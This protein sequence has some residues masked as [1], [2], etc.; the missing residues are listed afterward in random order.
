MNQSHV[1]AGLAALV[2]LGVLGLVLLLGRTVEPLASGPTREGPRTRTSRPAGKPVAMATD[3]VSLEIIL[4]LKD[5][6]PTVWD[7]QVMVS[8]GKV[9]S[10][11]LQRVGPQQGKVKDATFTVRTFRRAL[12]MQQGIV[13]PIVHMELEA[14]EAARVSLKTEQGDF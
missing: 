7:G 13:R 11:R 4:G 10:L 14:P 12:P 5:D 3:R 9:R 1:R 8:R 2:T 6:E